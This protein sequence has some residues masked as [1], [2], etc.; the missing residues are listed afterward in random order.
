M[1]TGLVMNPNQGST[2]VNNHIHSK[3]TKGQGFKDLMSTIL[4]NEDSK[5]SL[6][7][8]ME[9]IDQALKQILEKLEAGNMNVEA[10]TN[11]LIESLNDLNSLY[12]EEFD[13]QLLA[14]LDEQSL[15]ELND[16]SLELMAML[17]F[18]KLEMTSN[19]LSFNSNSFDQREMN[20]LAKLIKLSDTLS[21]GNFMH[22]KVSELNLPKELI[23]KWKSFLNQVTSKAQI[24]PRQQGQVSEQLVKAVKQLIEQPKQASQEYKLQLPRDP[25]QPLNG[26]KVLLTDQQAVSR[27]E[28]LVIHLT[29]PTQQ[30]QSTGQ[31]SQQLIEQLQKMIQK[32]RFNQVGGQ[33]QLSIQL[34]PANLGD[35]TLR[36]TQIDGQMAVKISVS[37]QVAKEMLEGNLQQLRHLFSPN[38]VVIERQVDQMNS[39]EQL[40]YFD[41]GEEQSSQQEGEQDNQH[42]SDHNDDQAKK[43]FKDFL[44]EEEV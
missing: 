37:T 34:K 10:D 40:G 42:Q 32:T 28:Q 12:G 30:S 38:Q 11:Q 20:L 33:K 5:H 9:T 6:S 29:R 39:E 8:L 27:Q 23:S 7:E 31:T 15:M 24:E 41:Q 19:Q 2:M 18:Q 25:F 17:I 21:Q 13:D 3:T 16:D 43:S 14:L 22:Q 44:F 1:L 4:T 35:M 36:F 26:S